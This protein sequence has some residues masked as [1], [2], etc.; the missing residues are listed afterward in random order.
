MIQ[1]E[2][3]FYPDL[4][5][6]LTRKKKRLIILDDNIF[7]FCVDRNSNLRQFLKLLT[8]HPQSPIKTGPLRSKK[9]GRNGKAKPQISIDKSL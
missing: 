7:I 4:R 1:A 3:K 6:N 8:M 2:Q 9:N 5:Y